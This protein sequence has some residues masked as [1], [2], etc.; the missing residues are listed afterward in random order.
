MR[1]K[2][3]IKIDLKS[4]SI[5]VSTVINAPKG[6]VWDAISAPGYLEHCHPFCRRNTVGH[7]PGKNSNDAI[8]YYNGLI[9]RRKFTYW[10]ENSGYEL[11]I[12]KNPK[13]P[14]AHVKWQIVKLDENSNLLSITLTPNVA[15]LLKSYPKIFHGT[16]YRFKMRSQ[17]ADYLQSVLRGCAFYIETGNSVR[18][19]QFGNHPLFSP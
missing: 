12:G 10:S 11:D 3:A 17:L 5:S 9:L 8:E 16:I 2:N 7:W 19:N 6:K 18:K 14:V 4:N 1:G 13:R 15:N